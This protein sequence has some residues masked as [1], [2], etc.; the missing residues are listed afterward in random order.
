MREEEEREV[1]GGRRKEEWGRE[2]TRQR[3]SGPSVSVSITLRKV[4][5]CG[6]RLLKMQ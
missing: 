6:D 5:R 1:G 4:N 3:K 2:K